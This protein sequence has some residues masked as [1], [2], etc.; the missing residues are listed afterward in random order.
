MGVTDPQNG[1]GQPGTRGW[2][3]AL[4][5]ASLALNLAIGGF[6]AGAWLGAW[7]DMHSGA[8]SGGE[9]GSGARRDN[10]LGPLATAMRSEDW[11]AMREAWVSRNPDLKRGHAQLRADYDPLLAA[12]RATPF[13][14][15][16]MQ[17][18]LVTISESNS[19]RLISASEVMGAYLA[20]LNETERRAYAERLEHALQPK[21]KKD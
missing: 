14:A 4:L 2:V 17:D 13:E 19:R 15:G 5:A 8:K 3:R 16:A 20:T 11:R 9:H 12:L 18:A 6:F 10:G 7:S 1:A 21:K